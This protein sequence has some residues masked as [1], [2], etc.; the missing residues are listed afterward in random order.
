MTIMVIN[1]YNYSLLY[2]SL[3]VCQVPIAVSGGVAG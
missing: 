3:F 2:S 1:K